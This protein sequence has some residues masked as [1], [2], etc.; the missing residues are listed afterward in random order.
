M[1]VD[2][3]SDGKFEEYVMQDGDDIELIFVSK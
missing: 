1:N 3:N 2:G